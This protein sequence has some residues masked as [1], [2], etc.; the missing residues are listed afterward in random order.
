M[1]TTSNHS[2]V[3]VS[4]PLAQFVQ[5]CHWSDIP[6]VVR[7]EAKRSLLNYFST[8]LSA[9]FDPTIERAAQV[10]GRF[11]VGP[12]ATVIGRGQRLDMLTAAALNTMAAN[13]FDFDDTHIP[14]IIHPT[15][16][17][18]T[19]HRSKAVPALSPPQ[20]SVDCNRISHKLL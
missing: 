1:T 2:A 4:L 12:Q 6:E 10:Y 11:S 18:F 20:R 5:N 16:P 8:A 9:C 3:N 15:S 14:T 19:S 7:H 17:R 13:V